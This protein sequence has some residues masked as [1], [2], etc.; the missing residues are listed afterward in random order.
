MIDNPLQMNK[1][2]IKR[3]L[4]AVLFIQMGMMVLVGLG[5]FGFDTPILRQVVGFVYL[6]FL[7]GIIILRI[8]RFHQLRATEVLLYSVGLSLGFNM[9][10][11]FIIDLILP[12]VGI[13]KPI[14]T[15]PVLITWAV[16]LG[17]LSLIA[18]KRDKGPSF[19]SAFKWGELLSPPVLFLVMLPLLAILGTQLVNLYQVNAILII[20]ICLIGLVPIL[21]ILTKFIPERLYPLAIYSIALSLLWYFALVSKYLVQWDSFLEYH[22]FDLVVK[23]GFWNW[24]IPNNFNAMLSVTILPAIFS[25]LLDISGTSLF[26]IIYPLWFALVPLGLYWVYRNQFSSKQAFSAVFFFVGIYIFFLQVPAIFRQMV[27]ELFY[28]LLIM[29][30]VNKE[31]TPRMKGL[32]IAF[33]ICLVISHYS[34]SYLYIGFLI[35]GMIILYVLKERNFNITA[36]SVVI[37]LVICLTW[38]MYISSSEPISSIANLGKHIY[39]NIIVD[40][41][42]IFSRDLSQ[43]LVRSSPDALNLT[44]KLLWYLILF[45]MAIGSITLVSRM[46]RRVGSSEYAALAVG[47]Y[48]VLGSCIIIPYFSNMLGVGRMVHIA[49]LILAPFCILGAELIFSSVSYAFQFIKVAGFRRIDLAIPVTVVMVLFFLFNT[50]LPFEIAKS[51][52]GRTFPLAYGEINSGRSDIDFAHLVNLRSSSPT[53]QEVVCAEWLSKARDEERNIYATYY[54]M[55]VPVLVSYGMIPEKQICSLT[56]YTTK[57]DI[58]GNYIFLGYVNVILG[59]GTTLTVEGR[60]D[61]LLGYTFHWDISRIKPLVDTSMRIYANGASVV[62]WAP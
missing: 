57:E 41:L 23:S 47:N 62:Y 21:T 14:S 6:T 43:I 51:S 8:L 35:I 58:V 34:L 27:A 36:Y 29:I 26:K 10:L 61:A 32:Y 49:S 5:A 56:P 38:Y 17:L 13:S 59:S 18:Y 33:C 60:P 24:E 39:D 40:F 7:P 22:F 3:F 28:V 37:L 15:L 9:F 52:L 30:I 16:I 25:Q 4:P 2:E 55:G 11:G 45:F 46:R 50:G 1:W 42:N 20:L 31:T 48:I 53:Q 44:Y 12:L 19:T 54:Q